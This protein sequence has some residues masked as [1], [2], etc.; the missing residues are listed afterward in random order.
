MGE[1][2]HG[3]AVLVGAHGLLIRGPSGSGKSMLAASLIGGGA[4]LVAD[5]QV[6]LA[7]CHGRIV[8]TGPA[9]LAGKLELRGRGILAVPHERSAVIR[10]IVDL[11]DQPEVERLP[12]QNELTAAILGV[13]LP[14][15]P[16]PA[17]S[18][19]STLLV[20][21]ALRALAPQGQGLRVR[22]LW[23]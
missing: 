8:A 2:V 5:D 12:E 23:G 15:Q 3:T 6:F 20:D 21:A 13:S 19:H 18:A 16:A 17:R 11:L 4:R 22:Q 1:T 9:T 14:R 7:A 10:L